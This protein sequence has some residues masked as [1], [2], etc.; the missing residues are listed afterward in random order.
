M[1]RE[2][3]EHTEDVVR[4]WQS[5]MTTKEIAVSLG[6]AYQRAYS[7]VTSAIN[8]GDLPP[9]PKKEK[10]L[11]SD[12]IYKAYK[13][14]IG[15]VGHELDKLSEEMLEYWVAEAL[16]GRYS[17]MCELIVDVLADEYYRRHEPAQ[18]V[19]ATIGKEVV[20]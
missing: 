3:S 16:T 8:R 20:R 9:R 2:R 12:G 4:M 15:V 18:A 14:P 19:I 5:G 6:I 1:V 13:L 10:T 11:K 7:I 17:S